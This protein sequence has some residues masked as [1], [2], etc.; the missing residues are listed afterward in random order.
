MWFNED[1]A[2]N[3]FVVYN[4]KSLKGT[5]VIYLPISRSKKVKNL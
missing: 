5:L 1:I 3:D 4:D 2:D